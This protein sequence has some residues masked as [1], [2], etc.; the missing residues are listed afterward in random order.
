MKKILLA[1]LILSV[2]SF[3]TSHTT[4]NMGDMNKG[5]NGG[6]MG[7]MMGNMCSPEMKAKMEANGMMKDGK[8]TMMDGE[9]NHGGMMANMTPEQKMAM[10]KN[11]IAIQEK[12]LEVRK[13]MNT[14]K[15]DT[16][17]I[18][19]LNAEIANMKTKHMESMQKMMPAAP[20]KN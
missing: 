16:A 18:E 20:A 15:P 12:Q 2:A 3:A 17:K 14:A 4:H 8:C 19:K 11:M 7:G 10:E 5:M 13:L 6:M 9:M 1:T